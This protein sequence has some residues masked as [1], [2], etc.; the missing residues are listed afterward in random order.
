[1]PSFKSPRE[2]TRRRLGQPGAALAIALFGAGAVQAIAEPAVVLQSAQT[3]PG[4]N[5]RGRVFDGAGSRSVVAIRGAVTGAR[6]G[7]AQIA[8]AYEAIAAGKQA[9]VSDLVVDGIT[10]EVSRGCVQLQGDRL[11]IR[12]LRCTMVG[13]PQSSMK[14]LPFGLHILSGSNIQVED[15][16]FSGFQLTGTPNAYWNGD[17]VSVERDVREISMRN[18]TS[19][20]NTDAGFDLKPWVRLDGVSATGN[21]RN[22]RLWGG[23]DVGTMTIGDVT[24]RGGRAGCMGIWVHGRA[25][26]PP[27]P[28]RIEHLVVRM[29]KPTTIIRVEMGAAAISIGSCDIKA[30]PG[31]VL[32]KQ[33]E[34]AQVTL[35]PT[36]R[37][38]KVVTGGGGDS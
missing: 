14:N 3:W 13:G 29:T 5:A 17:G 31:S 27:T 23:G 8:D 37:A 22:Y 1:M 10:A 34:Q 24:K 16:S 15:S 26:G 20:N 12:K 28:L 35:G 9:Q 11:V 19:D 2:G 25:S 30:P 18:V 4:P 6:V 36:C 33:D 21:C 7:P 32:V 38:F